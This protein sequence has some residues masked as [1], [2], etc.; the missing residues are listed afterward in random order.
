MLRIIKRNEYFA[1][2]PINKQGS[3]DTWFY[4]DK[5]LDRILHKTLAL[6]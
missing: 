4:H 5:T 3:E 6:V 2:L 1:T